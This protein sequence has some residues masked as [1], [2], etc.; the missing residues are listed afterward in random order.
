MRL[1]A[2][3]LLGAMAGSVWAAGATQAYL[4]KDPRIMGMGGTNV[5]V[6][7]Y[8]ASLFHNPA[9]LS[10][11][12][13]SHGWEV[14]LIGLSVQA[15]EKFNDFYQDLS[16]AG[17]TD[18]EAVVIDVLQRYNGDH[19]HA[20]VSNYSSLSKN[21]DA[22]AWSIG[23]LASADANLIPHANSAD[24]FV[25][26]Q[27]RIYGGVV[28][29]VSKE[30]ETAVGSLSL[31]LG[32]KFI[33]QNSYEGTVGVA[34]IIDNSDDIF[35]YLQ[36]NY[37]K[38]SSGYGIDA[39]LI[40]QPFADSWLRP[41][42]GISVLNIGDMEMDDYYGSNPMT[43]NLG[44]AVAPEISFLEHLIIA[45]DYVDLTNE[46]KIR[47]YD[48]DEQ[49]VE[50]EENDFNKHFR[51]GVGIGLVDNSWVTLTLNGGWYQGSYT[52]GVDF[53]LS[54]LHL[55]FSTYAEET[56]AYGISNEDRRYAL[57]IGIGW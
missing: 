56:G 30:F 3:A 51:A 43:V 46:N 52:A 25:E 9:G 24:G 50:F 22:V 54:V 39:G 2:L 21:S 7:G 8:S 40:Y 27:S 45:A 28:I 31:G 26:S 29:G 5:A 47:F 19:F 57:G 35:Q 20:D 44:A 49:V 48:S 55:Q 41:S 1:G 15:S 53:M 17:D 23:F 32:G 10:Q 18:D 4:Y 37:E 33:T 11:L 14:E 12:K 6:G 36:D 34:E 13:K 16:D 42:F 38:S